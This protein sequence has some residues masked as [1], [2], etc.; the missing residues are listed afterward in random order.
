MRK[1]ANGYLA[2][3]RVKRRALSRLT[4]LQGTKGIGKSAVLVFFPRSSKPTGFGSWAE[5]ERAAK[6]RK[7]DPA[8]CAALE[9]PR[10][11]MICMT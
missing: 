1:S 7:V 9:R 8:D 10:K 6:A 11:K 5:F 3:M 2:K 4:R